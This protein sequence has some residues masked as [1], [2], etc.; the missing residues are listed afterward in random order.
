MKKLLL[1]VL[2]FSSLSAFSGKRYWIGGG[3]TTGWNAS[4][5]TNW[6]ATSGGTTRVAAPTTTDSVYFDGAGTN[7]NSNSVANANFPIKLLIISAG[8]TST[9][10]LS[11]YVSV[12]GD[13]T[14]HNG[15]TLSGAVALQSSGAGTITTGGKSL[16][17]FNFVTNAGTRVLNGNMTVTGV[18]QFG[19]NNLVLNATTNETLTIN[20]TMTVG[21]VVSGTVKVIKTGGQWTGGTST[22]FGL[23]MDI[24][25]NITLSNSSG[26][27]CYGGTGTLTY[28]SGTVTQ[29][30]GASLSLMGTPTLDIDGMTWNSILLN[31]SN[32]TITLAATLTATTI[33]IQGQSS[34]TNTFSGSYGFITDNLIIDNY[35]ALVLTLVNGVT[36]EVI[37]D[38]E[39]YKSRVGSIVHITSDHASNKAILK[40]DTGAFSNVLASFTRIDASSGRTISTFNG[41]ITDCLNIIE[42]HDCFGTTVGG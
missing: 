39:C 2:I 36:Y 41:T 22:V 33:T 10:T 4:P 26:G 18:I 35:A 20:G 16:V 8:Y 34:A 12:N 21:G 11:G 24:Q 42:C 23:N 32:C 13:I 6:S 7:G 17:N 1:L 15:F 30:A 28:V 14:L 19:V 38:F 27:V 31:T 40:I 9:L 25:G 5:T 3:T 37:Y 29:Q